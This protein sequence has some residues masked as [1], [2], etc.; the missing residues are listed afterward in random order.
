MPRIGTDVQQGEITPPEIVDP[1]VGWGTEKGPVKFIERSAVISECT[2]YRYLLR[3]VWDHDKPRILFVMLNPSTADAQVD[4]PTIRSCARISNTL[5]YGSLEVINLFGL[6]A[7]D[8]AALDQWDDPVGPRNDDVAAAAI[9]R[10]DVAVCAWGAHPMARR[11]RR[12]ICSMIR[13]R[14]PAV[15][16]LGVTKA[17]AP[18]HPLY[19]KSFTPLQVYNS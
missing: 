19:L 11:R 7:T 3:R 16:C 8:P 15:Y 18:K 1:L 6:R 14:R 4:D 12:T 17:G 2:Y 10:C 13:V 5:G 9:E